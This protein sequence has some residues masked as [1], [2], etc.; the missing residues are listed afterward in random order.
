MVSDAVRTVKP[1]RITFWFP[2]GVPFFPNALALL[3]INVFPL[4]WF[5]K[6]FAEACATAELYIS[7]HTVK[8]HITNIH[9]K[10]GVRSRRQLI[11][12][13]HAGRKERPSAGPPATPAEIRPRNGLGP[14]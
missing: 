5:R 8:N 10:L 3:A 12:L 6:P 11:S 14:Q 7:I 9:Q 4:V 2:E 1:R 13:F